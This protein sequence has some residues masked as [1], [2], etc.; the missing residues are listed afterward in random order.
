MKLLKKKGFSLAEV[1]IAAG[2]LGVV[3][4][5]VMHMNQSMQKSAV[6][7][8]V[9]TEEIEL[10]NTFR[11]ALSDLEACKKT[12]DGVNVGGDLTGIKNSSGDLTYE[13]G[14]TYGNKA[15][16]ITKM[17]VID[18]G[19]PDAF[20]TRMVTLRTTMKKNKKMA[21]GSE[22]KVFDINIR[23]SAA[24]DSAPITSCY[25]TSHGIISSA[26]VLGCSSLNGVWDS[27]TKKC[28]LDSYVLKTGDTMSG[29][30]NAPLFKGDVEAGQVDSSGKV[31][32]AELCTGTDCI[33]VNQI[34]RSNN[35]CNNNQV[36]VGIRPNGN[37][38][39]LTLEC[40]ADELFNGIDSSGNPICK[41]L[42]TGG[43]CPTNQYVV[44]IKTNGTV[45]CA[46]LPPSL[47]VTC[48]VGKV[49]R[50]IKR[51]G[52]AVCVD[53]GAGEDCSTGAVVIGVKKN[54]E[55]N[56]SKKIMCPSGQALRG[57]NS[58][59]TPNC[60]EPLT[61]LPRRLTIREKE[62]CDANEIQIH[63]FSL[64]TCSL[65]SVKCQAGFWCRGTEYNQA[66][67]PPRDFW[68]D[69]T[70]PDY[71]RTQTITRQVQAECGRDASCL[72][73]ITF[74][75]TP[76]QHKTHCLPLTL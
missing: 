39:C 28:D 70:G 9:K 4:L 12:F 56:C 61:V 6:T 34:A 18:R 10:R 42:P 72:A 59:G 76:K 29:D 40:A 65:S 51:D 52:T 30:L 27:A 33:K 66:Q 23:V 37:T 73:T 62:F 71:K 25:D 50:R 74:T 64:Q 24:S 60:I 8:E 3:S 26:I 41:S 7:A 48:P 63:Q 57:I 46:P 45:T 15:L 5:G 38:K 43:S 16:T 54:G 49:L 17:S 47:N 20:G 13:V 67:V 55:L 2:M 32:A 44:E 69:S 14:K 36:S 58:D 68:S 19:N 31:V 75:C 53:K 11:M 35:L 1:M 22:R 21:M